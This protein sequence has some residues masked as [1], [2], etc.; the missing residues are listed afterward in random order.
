[1]FYPLCMILLSLL[2]ALGAFPRIGGLKRAYQR[3]RKGGAT[4]EQD[5]KA[6]KLVDIA[7]VDESNVSS[8]WNAIIPL[9]ALVGGTVLFD[10]DLLHGIVI[11]LIVHPAV[12]DPKAHDCRRVF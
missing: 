6:E 5:E 2:L 8:A 11:T 9:A 7:D 1:M 3:V 10:N 12:R 4:F